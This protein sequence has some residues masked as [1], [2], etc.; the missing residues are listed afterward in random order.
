M[1]EEMF[2]ALELKDKLKVSLP[3]IRKWTQKGMPCKKLGGRLVRFEMSS[4][5]ACLWERPRHYLD[6]FLRHGVVALIEPDFSL[7]VDMPL[8]EQLWNTYRMRTLG[9]LWQDAGLLVVPNLTWSDAR[10]FS[11]C[12]AGIPQHAPVVACECRTAGQHD[13]DRRAF[14]RGFTHAVKEVQPQHVLI[15]GGREHEYWL[16]E[17]L[18]AGPTYTLLEA[19][20]SARGKLRARQGRQLK[21][22]HQLNLFTGGSSQWVAEE[23]VAA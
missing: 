11:F 19:W 17:H 10:S 7:W 8:A 3:A 21:D 22:R 1:L 12:F 18:P 2:T 15:Y 16:T 13:D 6:L 14:L 23:A 5:L 20:T 9:Q 4:V